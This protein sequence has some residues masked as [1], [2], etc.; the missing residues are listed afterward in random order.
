M[1]VRALLA[2]SALAL[3]AVA[4]AQD[5][6]ATL[7]AQLEARLLAA[8]HIAI[9]ATIES[10]GVIP[11]NLKGRS[12]LFDRNR[13]TWSYAGDF[14][15]QPAELSLASDGR[16]L[17]LKSGT[18]AEQ[19]PVGPESNRA[20]LAVAALALSAAAS[21]QD[22]PAALITQLEVRLLAAQHVAIE[23]TIESHGVIPSNL[24]G[25]SELFDRNRATWSYAGDFA[26]Q[27]AELSLASDGRA[28]DM[29]SGTRA[30]QGPVGPES[31]RALLIG[32]VR[33]GLLHNLARLSG[34]AA[35]DHA[36]GGVEQWV[37][38]DSFRPTTYAIGGDLEGMMSFGFDLVVAGNTS[39]S[40]RL[41]LDPATGLP[42]RRQ[43]TVRFPQGDMTVTE[44]Y[45]RF[46]V[47]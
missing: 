28:L 25:R 9:D 40:A 18:R 30:E 22:D 11:S 14:A 45:T 47:E 6:P 39:G 17:D 7:I 44:D 46:L 21:A 43:L 15:G 1:S 27:P 26:G 20:L 8:R 19:G 24:K 38:L 33:M 34:L 36:Q 3:S 13:A 2:I 4:S 23:A 35:P 10:R 29:K 12:E 32:L 41:W 37:R 42:R 5:D 31:N 16:A